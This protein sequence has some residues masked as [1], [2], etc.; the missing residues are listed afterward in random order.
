[1][2]YEVITL[3]LGPQYQQTGARTLAAADQL[4]LKKIIEIARDIYCGHIGSEYMYI[5]NNFV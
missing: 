3:A 1:M 4:P 5:R 2:L